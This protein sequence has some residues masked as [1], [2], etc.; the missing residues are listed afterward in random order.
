MDR[1]GRSVVASSGDLDGTK[2]AAIVNGIDEQI[3]LVT[4]QQP[5]KWE[6]TR[7][8]WSRTPFKFIPHTKRPERKVGHHEHDSGKA[9]FLQ[10][11]LRAA[12][13]H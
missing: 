3:Q 4:T 5:N 6:V 12:E 8:P 13:T 10:A 1:K 9:H 2:H 11:R 7:H